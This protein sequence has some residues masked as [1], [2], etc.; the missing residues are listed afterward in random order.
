MIVNQTVLAANPFIES[1]IAS[2][3]FGKLIFLG[4]F[5][6]SIISWVVI[7]YKGINLRNAKINA[8]KFHKNLMV[9][10]K[11]AQSAPLAIDLGMQISTN[12][13]NPF[14]EIYLSLKKQIIPLLSKNAIHE[15]SKV[16][17]LSSGNLD[18]LAAALQ[19][20]SALQMKKLEKNLYIL[21]TIVSLAP[22][23]GLLGT[24]WGILITF[25]NM[26]THLAGGSQAVLEGLSLALTT[27]V[28]GLV[29]AIPA[30]I[31]YN[32]LKNQAKD[33]RIDMDGFIT[34]LITSVELK[35]RTTLAKPEEV[36]SVSV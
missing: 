12:K 3:L 31:G 4:L 15:S 29:D 26:Q 19:V 27:T 28:L 20:E 9:N 32:F 1:Y 7:I 36:S 34:H 18:A 17:W 5:A 21:S 14:Q 10:Q 35:Y 25:S 13:S 33:F 22:F 6:L 8:S 24:V 11:T 16:A 23:L 30:L 2:D